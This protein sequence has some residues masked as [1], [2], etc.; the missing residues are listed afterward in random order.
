VE[1]Q[2]EQLSPEEQLAAIYAQRRGVELRDALALVQSLTSKR[3]DR[4]ERLRRYLEALKTGTDV[5]SSLPPS[6]ARTIA[7]L[8]LAEPQQDD[9]DIRR[10]VALATTLKSLLGDPSQQFQY[11]LLKTLLERVLQQPQ[12]DTAAAILA[13][14]LDALADALRRG[15]GP[16]SLLDQLKEVKQLAEFLGYKPRDEFMERLSALEKKIE[17]LGGPRQASPMDAIK[18]VLG[19]LDEAK[20]V[21]EAVGYK[22]ERQQLTPIE[23]QEM[24]RRH[25]EELRKKIEKEMEVERERISAVKEII[26]TMIREV[27]SQFTQAIAEAQREALRQRLAQRAAQGAGQGG[28]EGGGGQG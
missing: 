15:N 17:S 16:S 27:G 19:G 23:V 14:K 5:F 24:L 8:V 6:V 3:E 26:L 9:L 22:V 25:E 7:P 2:P 13:E 11:E 28:V 18:Q 12:Q 21:L 1:Q 20:Q 10:T 4:V